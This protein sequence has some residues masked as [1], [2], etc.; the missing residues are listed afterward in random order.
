MPQAPG[1]HGG[2]TQPPQAPKIPVGN[3][4][5]KGGPVA[6]KAINAWTQLAGALATQLPTSL[7]RAHVFRRAALRSLR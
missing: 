5:G 6:P 7:H 4:G 2:P 3:T 1:A